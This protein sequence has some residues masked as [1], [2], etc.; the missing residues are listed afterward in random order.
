MSSDYIPR[1]RAELLRA[2]AAQQRRSRWASVRG[3]LR[4][5]LDRLRRRRKR[6]RRSPRSSR[7]SRSS[8]PSRGSRTS[9]GRRRRG[10]S[11]PR[12][13]THR[14]CGLP[15]SSAWMHSG[16]A[17]SWTSSRTGS[18]PVRSPTGG[19]S[20][21]PA[22]GDPDVPRDRLAGE[23]HEP[24]RREARALPGRRGRGRAPDRGLHAGVG[25]VS[26]VVPRRRGEDRHQGQRSVRHVHERRG[27]GTRARPARGIWMIT[28]VGENAGRAAP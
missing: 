26:E 24:A 18:A 2:G 25:G 10:H 3:A 5:A 20:C 8:W 16:S 11:R 4:P 27:G 15:K 28:K 14:R 23:V 9:N 1:L 12:T 19:R 6:W 21:S 13:R 22:G 17:P 7:S